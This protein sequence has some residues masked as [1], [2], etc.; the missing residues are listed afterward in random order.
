MYVYTHTYIYIH[1]LSPFLSKALSSWAGSLFSSRTEVGFTSLSVLLRHPFSGVVFWCPVGSLFSKASCCCT[2]VFMSSGQ[3]W[4]TSAVCLC[5][6][7]IL[8]QV[9]FS[10][11]LSAHFSQEFPVV[12]LLF[13]GVRV[14]SEGHPLLDI[15]EVDKVAVVM[16]PRFGDAQGSTSLH[17]STHHLC[18]L[19]HVTLITVGPP[20]S[21][22]E[23]TA[24]PGHV[25]EHVRLECDVV[26][27]AWTHD[28]INQDAISVQLRQ[29]LLLQ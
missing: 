20:C 11:A 29:S 18:D 22:V 13:S 14:K 1:S 28:A 5:S 27:P 3:V 4:R 2:P 10:V 6:S 8:S 15:T 16:S 7:D 23:V 17:I 24:V 26:V 19:A 25:P 21:G 12:A 9:F